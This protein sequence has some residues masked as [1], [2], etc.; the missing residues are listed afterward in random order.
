MQREMSGPISVTLALGDKFAFP[1]HWRDDHE[2]CE[3][4]IFLEHVK[5]IE[6]GPTPVCLPT[7][8]C[9]YEFTPIPTLSLEGDGLDGG[10][11]W[12]PACGV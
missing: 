7:T 11:G 10:A 1:I 3:Y 12:R 8:I 4:K 2:F 6:V 9:D 5:G